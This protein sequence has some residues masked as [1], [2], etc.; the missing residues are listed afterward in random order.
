MLTAPSLPGWPG[1]RVDAARGNLRRQRCRVRRV[2]RLGRG[3]ACGRL[4]CCRRG[5]SAARSRTW[6]GWTGDRRG[7]RPRWSGGTAGRSQPVADDERPPQGREVRP[8]VRDRGCGARIDLRSAV[9]GERCGQGR[10]ARPSRPLP[11][12][13][14]RR[15]ARPRGLPRNHPQR[16]VRLVMPPGGS[17][18]YGG[19]GLPGW[20]LREGGRGHARV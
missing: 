13:C 12:R 5:R 7:W 17:G 15:R 1:D 4:R 11:S 16:V 9:C 18:D 10:S 14:R 3:A 20:G 19:V 6:A 8:S 2:R